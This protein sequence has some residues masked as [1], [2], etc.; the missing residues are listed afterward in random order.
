MNRLHGVLAVSVV[1]L[2]AA[3]VTIPSP[4]TPPPAPAPASPAEFVIRD[5]RLFDG[6]QFHDRR[7]VWVRDGRVQAVA[8]ALDVPTHVAVV[9]GADQQG[10]GVVA[11]G[12][13]VGAFVIQRAVVKIGPVAEHRDAQPGHIVQVRQQGRTG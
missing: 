12:G 7:S 6:E 5:V 10:A 11:V 13:E 8:A 3:L 9:E 4:S 1:V 2:V